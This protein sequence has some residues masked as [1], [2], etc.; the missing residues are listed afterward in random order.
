MR[1]SSWF[2]APGIAILLLAA[3]TTPSEGADASAA[4]LLDARPSGVERDA[5]RT[6]VFGISANGADAAVFV[7]ASYDAATPAP[8]LVLLHGAHQQGRELL[9]AFRREAEAQGAIVIAPNSQR[10]TWDLID[11]YARNGAEGM[12]FG[13]DVGRIDGLLAEVFAG[14][15]IDPDRVAIAGFSDGAS[16]ALSLGLNNTGLFGSIAAIAPGLLSSWPADAR[17]RI[18]L[19]HGQ[20]D[21]VLPVELSRDGLAP[22][23]RAA[24]LEVEVSIHDGG[25]VLTDQIILDTFAWLDW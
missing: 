1:P 11:S 7:P 10:S 24:G 23:L 14:Y 25:H 20:R 16:Y 22:Q 12:G 13:A 21:R 5:G 8:L 19:V 18:L 17:T 4:P 6:G 15:A 9:A 3:C 2:A